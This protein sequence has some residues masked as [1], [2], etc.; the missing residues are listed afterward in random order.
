M[1]VTNTLTSPTTLPTNENDIVSN[2]D[3]ILEK[4][5]FLKLLLIEL[6]YQDP[7]DPM[8]TEK[9][10]SQTS[11]LASLEASTNTNKA[12]EELSKTLVQTSGMSI[13]S[14]IGKMGSL[15]DNAI[16]LDENADTLF[17][18]YFA[19]DVKG[20]TVTV[21]D[22]DGN[23]VRTLDIADLP[24]GINTFSWDGTN[25]NGQLLQPGTYYVE[26][27]YTTEA[28]ETKTAAPGVYPIESVR[29]DGGEALLKM[30]SQYFPLD[31]IKEIYE[32]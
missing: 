7:T 16:I 30:G 23:P 9:I 27:T 18:I 28:G 29:F 14:A 26:A 11:E 32:G 25:D 2:P 13:V 3:G 5:D 17:E 1:D 22:V 6:Q 15:G 8:D 4:D 10:L 12:L 19:D 20:G 21:K 24:K 31:Q